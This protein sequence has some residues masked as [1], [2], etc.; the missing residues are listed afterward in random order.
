VVR[1][2]RRRLRKSVTRW[3][4]RVTGPAFI[5]LAALS[6]RLLGRTWRL[7]IEG[8]NPLLAGG[9]AVGAIWHRDMLIAA[10]AFRDLGYSVPVSRSRDGDTITRL[11]LRLGYAPPPRGSSSAGGASALRGLVRLVRDGTPVS[12]PVDGPR[13]PERRSK[14]GVVSRSRLTGVPI[15]P[16]AFSARPCLRF[17]SWDRTVLP[18]PFARVTGRFGE[19]LFVPR[20]TTP[21]GE[22][23][24]ARDLDR[25]LDALADGLDARMGSALSGAAAAP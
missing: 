7:E 12:L 5:W 21:E 18:L 22:E 16:Y 23:R 24:I 20:D 1:G 11:L 3:L 9:S 19:P 13:G 15:T 17:A 10:Y 4:V 6:L 8:E 14:I 2:R 25:T